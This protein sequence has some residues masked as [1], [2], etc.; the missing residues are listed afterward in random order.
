MNEGAYPIEN[1]NDCE[2]LLLSHSQKYV[3]SI[4]KHVTELFDV[5]F[6]IRIEPGEFIEDNN[7]WDSPFQ[8][9]DEYG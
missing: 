8:K 1:L 6:R 7:V 9:I 5:P 3:I 4:L 2:G